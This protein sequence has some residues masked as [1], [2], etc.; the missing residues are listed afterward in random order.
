MKDIYLFFCTAICIFLVVITLYT[1]E[2]D[3]RQ[4]EMIKQQNRKIQD[5][6]WSMEK[7]RKHFTAQV[8]MKDVIKQTRAMLIYQK[9]YE[10]QF[11]NRFRY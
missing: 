9:H 8:T 6:R 11:K 10:K 2:K 3:T 7:L 5:M 4:D 1:I